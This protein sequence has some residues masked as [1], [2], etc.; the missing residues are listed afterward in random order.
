MNSIHKNIWPEVN[1]RSDQNTNFFDKVDDFLD[2]YLVDEESKESIV[3]IILPTQDQYLYSPRFD[4]W[5][6]SD[7]GKIFPFGMSIEREFKKVT[8][9]TY[10]EAALYI[11][12][13]F[14]GGRYLP[15]DLIT[16]VNNELPREITIPFE[17]EYLCQ[18]IEPLFYKMR[19]QENIIEKE[20]ERL[21][22]EVFTTAKEMTKP[23]SDDQP[24]K[25]PHKDRRRKLT[26]DEIRRLKK[27][28]RKPANVEFYE[29]GISSF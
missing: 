17:T 25:K 4:V 27:S 10:T 23:S 18:Y 20:Q 28:S 5:L 14:P 21:M 16:K 13:K 19:L 1:L 22:K 15:K 26:I 11:A 6:P 12:K 9:N 29:E 3:L 2:D 7:D 8:K 24:P